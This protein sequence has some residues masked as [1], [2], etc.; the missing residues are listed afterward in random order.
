MMKIRQEMILSKENPQ[1]K[2]VKSLQ[3]KKYRNQHGLYMIEGVRNSEAALAGRAEIIKAFYSEALLDSERGTALLATVQEKEISTF[4]CEEKVMLHCSDAAT[5]Q[6]IILLAKIPEARP[7]QEMETAHLLVL[8]GIQDPGNL[9]TILRTAWAAGIRAVALLAGT[10]D[11]YSPKVVRSA[12]G[13]LYHLDILI[14]A[15]S[16]A[17][18]QELRRK[19]Y[20]IW[21]TSVS[22]GIHYH[23]AKKGE[24]WALVIGGEAN[25]V[26]AISL[27][28]ATHLV[29]IPMAEGAESLNAAVA[30][31]ILMFG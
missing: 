9:G 31:G 15:D 18:Y 19:D 11:P 26:R 6:G 30:A 8:D 23:E 20:E 4:L 7:I 13:A 5:S 22:Q 29:T 17:F 14:I 12:M 1:I 2:L 3:Q 21:T 25:G 28:Y 10:V 24:K 16:A 27:Q